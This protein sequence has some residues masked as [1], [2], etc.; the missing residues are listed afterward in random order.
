[1]DSETIRLA[2]GYHIGAT[3]VRPHVCGATVTVDGHLLCRALNTGT[4][5]T[6]EPHSLCASGR[7]RPDGVTQVPWKRGRCLAWDATCPNT[8][9]QSTIHDM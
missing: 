9:A 6:R 4:L 2:A 1:M 5:A 8:F 7:K 3:V